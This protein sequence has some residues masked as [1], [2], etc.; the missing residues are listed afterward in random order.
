MR[1]KRNRDAP[2]FPGDCVELGSFSSD[3]YEGD[4]YASLRQV[5]IG[6]KEWRTQGWS[7]ACLR[8]YECALVLAIVQSDIPHWGS[9]DVCILC[10]EGVGWL[11]HF[12]I[13]KIE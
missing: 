2:F 7:E 1:A 9:Y 4:H 12:L 5:P 10:H 8:A 6:S 11:Q 3:G 13:R